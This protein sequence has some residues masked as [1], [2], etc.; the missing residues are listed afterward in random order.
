[1]VSDPTLQQKEPGTLGK[2]PKL[3]LGQGISSMSLE[4]L[5]APESKEVL[6][7]PTLLGGG[8]RGTGTQ[9]PMGR[10]KAGTLCTTE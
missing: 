5:M 6:T 1:M 2:S 7:K 4:H 8:W 10:A 9:E 3:G